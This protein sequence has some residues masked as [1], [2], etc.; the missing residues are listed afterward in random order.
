MMQTACPT[1]YPLIG[2]R[3]PRHYV[4]VSWVLA[5]TFELLGAKVPPQPTEI[6]PKWHFPPIFEAK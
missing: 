5:E 1:S 4:N 3:A 2:G 6:L